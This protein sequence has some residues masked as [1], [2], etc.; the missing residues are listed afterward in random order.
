MLPGDEGDGEAACGP[1]KLGLVHDETERLPCGNV[2][3]QTLSYSIGP[4]GGRLHP[5]ELYA[6]IHV[7]FSDFN[8]PYTYIRKN[9]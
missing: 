8:I 4:N 6:L 5:R 7:I 9:I 1:G 2:G 3:R